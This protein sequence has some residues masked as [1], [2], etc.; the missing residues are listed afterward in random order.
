MVHDPSS[1]QPQ[2]DQQEQHCGEACEA[3]PQPESAAPAAR[4]G[5]CAGSLVDPD[6]IDRAGREDQGLRAHESASLTM[7][8]RPALRL[9]TL[10]C[11][12]RWPVCRAA[13]QIENLDARDKL[14]IG[15]V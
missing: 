15:G 12:S 2:L 5:C 6:V 4:W 10:T 1:S 8:R 7:S 9:A 13:V 14:L 3:P 11:L